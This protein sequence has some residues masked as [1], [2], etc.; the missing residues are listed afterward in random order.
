MTRFFSV[1]AIVVALVAGLVSESPAATFPPL[2]PGHPVTLTVG[3]PRSFGYLATMWA[4]NTQ[5]PGLVI[6]YKYFPD[7]T[8]MLT[9]FNAGQVDV[10]EAGDVGA[11]QSYQNGGGISVIAVS[12]SNDL[13]CGLLVPKGSGVKTMADLRGKKVAFLKST[14]SYISFKHLI[15]KAHL[16]ESDFEIVQ[17]TGPTGN[18]AFASGQVDALFSINPNLEDL[19]A[20]TGGKEIISCRDAG[21][22]NLYPYLATA[23][24][25]KEKPA[26]LHAFIRALADTY[27]WVQANHQAQATLL[28]PK[29]GFS[30]ASILTT[31][32]QGAAALQPIDAKFYAVEQKTADEFTESG[33]LTKPIDVKAVFVPTFNDAI[34]GTRKQ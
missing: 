7:F 13:E 32:R 31:Y 30:E 34:T 23:A 15:A 18:K 27:K 12:A 2:D 1:V 3:V 16:A 24:A 9:A 20:Q 26:A 29:L 14:N 6:E 10:T 21:V 33:I 8:Q 4:R 25:V 28:A 17:I 19:A 11:L 5:V 22:Q